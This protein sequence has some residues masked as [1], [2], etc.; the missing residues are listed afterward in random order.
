M[1]FEEACSEVDYIIKHMDIDYKEKIPQSIIDFFTENKS[2]TYRVKL[3]PNKELKYQ[4]IKDE[5]KAFL[6]II[7]YK[8][9]ADEFEKNEF[10]N[11][12]KIEP[13]EQQMAIVPY[14]ENKFK[15]FIQKIIGFF[16]K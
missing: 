4:N 12:L 10:D 8:C 11:M 15:L 3:S 16:I 6:Q 1:R 2:V 9:F 13:N 14:K 5:T 7:Y